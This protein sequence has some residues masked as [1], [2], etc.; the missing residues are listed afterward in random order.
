VRILTLTDCPLDPTL[1]SGKT[2]L[3][4]TAGLRAAGHD[5]NVLEPRDFEP[6][7]HLVDRGRKFRR[8]WWA[9]RAVSR[10]R[11]RPYDL[12]EFYGEDFWAVAR[13]LRCMQPRPVL[14]GHTNGLE[15]LAHAR[16]AAHRPPGRLR[17]WLDA[18]THHR[19]SRI[20][21]RSVDALVC[22][23]QED[24]NWAVACGHIAAERTAV[25]EPGLDREYLEGELIPASARGPIVAYSGSWIARK[26]IDLLAQVMTKVL[27]ARPLARF[28][29]FGAAR[30]SPVRILQSFPEGIRHRVVIHGALSNA[31]LA[32]G[33]AKAAVF[34]FP[35][36]YEG[37]GLALAEAMA[38]GCAAVTTPTGLGAELV[39]GREALVIGFDAPADLEGAV[40][41]LLDDAVLRDRLAD[42]GRRRVVDLTWT[43]AGARLNN[44]YVALVARSNSGGLLGAQVLPSSGVVSCGQRS[45]LTE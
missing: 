11:A 31:E 7:R 3:M 2:V 23:C 38:R 30:S 36:R 5:V 22:L 32:A 13:H 18:L 41:R 9:R 45:D 35:S 33:L 24:R 25:I 42:A 34:V 21:L 16:L 15:L 12:V 19:F 10:K 4:Y 26:G 1:G 17:R 8:A 28:E 14:V 40:L 39:E 43:T 37:Y 27:M 44:L 29:I 6:A 20:W